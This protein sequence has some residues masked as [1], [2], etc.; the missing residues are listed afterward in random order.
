LEKE[1]EQCHKEADLAYQTQAAEKQIS[2]N[3][4]TEKTHI[5]Y[6]PVSSSTHGK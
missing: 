2:N 6:V 3:D 1:L 5:Q 4:P